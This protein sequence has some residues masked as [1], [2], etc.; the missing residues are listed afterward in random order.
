MTDRRCFV[1]DYPEVAHGGPDP[2]GPSYHGCDRLPC[3]K[4][5]AAFSRSEVVKLVACS[6]WAGRPEEMSLA[7]ADQ[8]LKDMGL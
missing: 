1:C 7:Q 6:H 8:Y 5:E 3:A 4:Y 2:Y